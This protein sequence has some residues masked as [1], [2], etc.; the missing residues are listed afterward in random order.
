MPVRSV[1]G[2][3]TQR[4]TLSACQRACATGAGE[5]AV[6][7]TLRL[8]HL[9]VRS[10]MP[11]LDDVNTLLGDNNIDVMCVTETWLQ[12]DMDSQFL[13]FPGYGA[14]RRDRPARGGRQ[15]RG[16]GICILYRTHL[17][18]VRLEVPSVGSPLEAL[19]VSLGGCRRPLV[20]GA[21]YRPPAAPAAAVEDLHDQLAHFNGLGRNVIVLGDMNLDLL[22]PGLPGPRS[23]TQM[24]QDMSMK[25]I[26]TDVT[27]PNTAANRAGP[28][29]LIDHV[30]VPA[31][32]DVTTTEVTPTSCSDHNLVIAQTRQQRERRPR[33]EIT[34]RSTRSLVPDALRLDLL[35]ADWSG[36]REAAGVSDKWS[37][38]L[39]VWTPLIDKHMPLTKFRPRHPPCP[40]LVND[41]QLRGDMRER[42]EARFVYVR[43]PTPENR[44]TYVSRRNAVKR[45]QHRAR[46]E[47]FA[48]SFRN[49]RRTTWKDIRRFLVSSRGSDA[50]VVTGRDWAN[51]LN[52]HFA[53]CGSRVAAEVGSRAD[54]ADSLGPR[55]R[56]VVSGAF[57]VY[58]AT[59]P[60]L[61][62]AVRQMS[63]SKACGDDGI[64]IAMIR[65][66]FPV[67]APHLLHVINH[68]IVSGTLPRAWKVAKV[69]PLH[70]A[71]SVS[72]PNN[73]RPIS[74][75]PTVAKLTERVICNQLMAYL[76]SHCVL[77]EE[78]HGFRPGHSTESAMLD[79]VGHVVGSIDEGNIAC[80]TTVDTSKAF[81]S[82]PHCRLLEKLGW[83]GIDAHWFRDWL[84]DRS[85]RVMDSDSAPVT[86]GVVQGSLLGPV[87]YLLYTNDVP[88]YFSDTKIVMYADDIQF[89]HSC[90]PC[91]VTTLKQ[92][93]EDTLKA[94]H[95]WF[96]DNSLKLNPSK[97]ELVLIKTRQRRI[98]DSFSVTFNG[99]TL[100]PTTKVK[101]LGVIVDAHLTWEAHVSLV[102]RRCYATLR[103]LSKLAYCLSYDVKKFLVESL[104]I[105]HIMYCITVWGGCGVTQR[106]RV[107]KVLNHCARIVFCS[108]KSEHVSPLLEELQWASVDTRVSER[109]MAMLHRLLNRLHVPQSL[110][111]AVEYRRD[112]S[113]RGTRAA[114]AGQ[115]QLPRVHTELARRSFRYR[116][117]SLW[118]E[119]P[120]DVRAS[121]SSA[122][123]RRRVEAWL[124]GRDSV[125]K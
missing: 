42:D 102:V 12:P 62:V 83:Y 53:S 66:S 97:T 38:W 94:A 56:R 81:D 39:S 80:L 115:L 43:D 34:V 14:I 47:F 122:V 76:Q 74:I 55:P 108:R 9:N 13:I 79:A 48:A 107:Q 35:T 119:A 68:S 70:K 17:R 7:Q 41:D 51:R 27:R 6:G 18:A 58:P 87:L 86:H 89:I 72:D 118:N 82:V 46:T 54:S 77:G 109:D 11:S 19:W 99:T 69:L 33:T 32:D 114:A 125:P 112:V 37:Q 60:E 96:V 4:Q 65:M 50:P 105:P 90:K 75:L 2:R 113:V 16:G 121:R 10:L 25:Q 98:P 103:G 71:G 110:R 124:T 104:V 59:L 111:D 44:E 95:A 22:T 84:C 88:C 57:R 15:A 101:L 78:Q 21:V 26:V 30:I 45:E 40:W 117:V 63:A 116:A 73:Y 31:I 120:A 3:L 67:I 100:V 24:L 106:R 85:Q 8:A 20:V 52:D 28:G 64:T 23:Y 29:S 123:F 91:N 1:P 36:V 5:L 93:V 61:S 49:T 92:N